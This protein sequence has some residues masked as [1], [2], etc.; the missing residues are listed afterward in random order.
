[1]STTE[2]DTD[3]AKDVLVIADGGAERLPDFQS[4]DQA[5]RL[6][7]VDVDTEVYTEGHVQESLPKEARV[8][9]STLK[10]GAC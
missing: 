7:E 1:M 9:F 2:T 10:G 8:S 4:D 5:Y 3:Y 6:V